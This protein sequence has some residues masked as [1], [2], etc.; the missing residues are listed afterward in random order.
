MEAE[1]LIAA[2]GIP[3]ASIRLAKSPEQAASFAQALGFPVVLKVASSDIVHKSD[4]GGVLLDLRSV[5]D[6][7]R[8]YAQLTET[9]Q[10]R[11]PGAHI[12]G[13]QVQRQIHEGQ[14]VIIGATRDATFGAL[15]MFGSGGVEAE[16]LKDVAFALAPLSRTEASELMGRTWAGRRLDGFRHLAPGD[17]AS[18]QDALISLSWLAYEHPEIKEIEINPL[19]VLEKGAF[20]LDVRMV[21]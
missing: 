16:G 12:D 13:I 20:A 21:L 6:V 17:K 2:Y 18:V 10:V 15:I 8:A 3:A 14:E 4:V 7:L 5:E 1:Q 11:R 19:R 9:I